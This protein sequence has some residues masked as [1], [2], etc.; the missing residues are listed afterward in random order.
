M[1]LAPISRG[2]VVDERLGRDYR[3]AGFVEIIIQMEPDPGAQMRG[4]HISLDA[5]RPS[6]VRAR[7]F[8]DSDSNK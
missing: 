1:R 5:R 8:I 6:S 3:I 7:T 4:P 2:A